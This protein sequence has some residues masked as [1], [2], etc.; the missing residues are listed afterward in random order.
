MTHRDMWRIRVATE[1]LNGMLASAPIVD[2]SKVDK[3]SWTEIAYKWADEI[4]KQS[5]ATFE[6]EVR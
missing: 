5:G 3:A 4:L 2:R 1:V 6:G